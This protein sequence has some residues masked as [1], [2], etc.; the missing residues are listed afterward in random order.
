[1]IT[2][3]VDAA[4]DER[5]WTR[6]LNGL[7]GATVEGLVRE[8]VLLANA[9]DETARRV[10]DHS[11]AEVALRDQF[12]AAVSRARGD[13]LLVVEGGVLLEAGWQE[14]VET[15]M[16]NRSRAACFARSP[17]AP[18]SY[19]QRML[20]PERPLA[21]GLLMPKAAALVE[22]NRIGASCGPAE[23]TRAARPGAIAAS[24]RPRP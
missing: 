8:V 12:F 5:A 15:H 13:W 9:D 18:R 6:T 16:Q 20:R 1:M 3:L 11:G 21:L 7:I 2:A 19:F 23:L 24:L 22:L 17:H 10:A 14:A 4:S